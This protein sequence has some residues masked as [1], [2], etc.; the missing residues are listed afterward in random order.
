[1]HILDLGLQQIHQ[2]LLDKKITI[3]ELVQE[4]LKR[5][6]ELQK[7]TNAFVT[8]LEKDALAQAKAYQQNLSKDNLFYGIPIA[9]KDN[10]STQGIL[11]TGSSNILKNYVPIFESTVT[12]KL[13][14]AHAINIGK[15]V[16]DELAMGGSG[17]TGN[18]GI[19]KNPLDPKRL[20]GGSSAGS[21][22]AVA[23][24]VVPF[25]LG[26]DTG[27]SVRKP[28][29]FGGVVGFKPTLGR[30]SRYGLFSFAPSLDT[31]AYFTYTVKD[32]AY[33][34]DLLSGYDSKDFTSSNRPKENIYPTIDGKVQ[35]KKIAILKEIYETIS[36]PKVKEKFDAFIKQCASIGL[37]VDFVSIDKKLYNTIYPTYMILSCAEATSN[38]ANL[39]GINFGN[40]Q[41]GNSVDEVVVH[42]RT[43]GFSEL[44]KRR[45]VLGSYILSK[46][47]QEKLFIKAKKLRRLIVEDMNRIFKE[48]DVVMLPASKDVAP[49]I[50]GEN[51][52]RLS[53]EYLLLEN[54]MAIGNFGGFPS[55]TIPCIQINGL[56]IGMNFT[57]AAYQDQKLLNIAYAIEQ[58]LGGK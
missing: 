16:L 20:I 4:S 13:K 2:A 34:F 24:H 43:K 27:D 31:V 46:E 36:N 55:I 8:I 29:S 3:E 51:L 45:F 37:Q 42:T 23:A 47:N 26:S 33:A 32:S 9:I 57:A 5:A 53:D 12:Q 38:N 14:D 18:T 44:I 7:E 19:V 48:Y 11:S 58:M 21:C 17:C 22:A 10:F 40:T 15:T 50:E 1:M 35:G 49:F 54:H 56:P 52:D 41:S 30:L 6:K 25:A 28:A 39:D